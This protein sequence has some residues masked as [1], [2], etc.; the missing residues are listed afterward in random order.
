M[1]N[2]M[3]STNRHWGSTLRLLGFATVLGVV[4]TGQMYV[5]VHSEDSSFTLYRAAILQLPFWYG[6]A[7]L[8][9]VIGWSLHRLQP[10]SRP[11]VPRAAIH[12]SLAVLFSFFHATVI[13]AFRHLI[14]FHRDVPVTFEMFASFAI[15]TLSTNLLG[16][17]TIIGI[18][19]A[20]D[21][22]RRYRE[23]ELLASQ[24]GEQLA[25]ARLQALRMQLNPHFLF[26]AMN[27]IAMQVRKA[28][29]DDAVR[30]LAGLSDLLRYMLEDS[31]P[32]EVPLSE[33]LVF[34]QRYL[35]I[36]QVRF[37]DRLRIEVDAAPATED[38]LVP[39][40]ILQ[41]LVENAIR[42]GISRRVQAGRV[43]IRAR[44]SDEQ[45]ILEVE[46]DG[47]GLGSTMTPTPGTGLGLKNTRARLSQLYPGDFA[48]E[49]TESAGGGTLATIRLPFRVLRR[50]EALA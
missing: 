16:Y 28:A 45:L 22:Y 9:P 46:D 12:I 6:W 4:A 44:R 37:Q 25:Q 32:P 50:S 19:Y 42:H 33:E 27:T 39:T 48:F 11:W 1:S 17:A 30:M 13:M 23:R 14:G 36:E 15:G 38:A 47:P 24:L 35:A 29:N 26:N 8:A 10:D 49:L 20:T 18:V 21:F 41:P 2:E 5:G 34:V 31:R 3:P 7:L 43:A 40:L